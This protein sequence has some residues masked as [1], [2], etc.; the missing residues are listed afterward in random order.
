[1]SF[2]S[3]NNPCP[4]ESGLD[5]LY[6]CGA[7]DREKLNNI[8][9][10]VTEG[11]A[12]ITKL[13]PAVQS[14]IDEMN[15]YPD[16]FP[17]RVNLFS[18]YV[19]WVKMS[20]FWYMESVFLDADRI[21]GTYAFE[22][23]LQWLKAHADGIQWQPTPVIFHTAFCGSTLMSKALATVYD[24][25]PLRE[26]DALG[27]LMVFFQSNTI[28]DTEK[29]EWIG[30]VMRL[31]SRR[32]EPEQTTVVKAN[33]A[34]N[35]MMKPLLEWQQDVP[36]L[37]MYTPLSEF[38]AGCFKAENRQDWIRERNGF[39]KNTAPQL[40]KLPAGLVIENDDIG[41]MAAIYWCYNIALYLDARQQSPSQ[42]RS[43]EFNQMLAY[44]IEIIT[45][46][47]D[48]FQ[49]N[50]QSGIFFDSEIKNL[51]GIYSKGGDQPYSADT[52]RQEIDDL[53]AKHGDQLEQS[54]DLAKQ[55]LGE[56]YP[57]PYLPGSLVDLLP[58]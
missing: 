52:R 18:D 1:M 28:S 23:D 49:L 37:F 36:V 16:L 41:K 30:H 13:T 3:T 10:T 19:Q 56:Q 42:I 48:F 2:F 25:L 4:C 40:L 58:V 29:H 31:F 11:E 15:T 35:W 45:A 5:Y 9:N 32:F 47:G 50:Q 54:L 20:P 55:I 53:L 33:D 6:C 8:V 43:L 34:A 14:C 39:I 17:V 57:E 7:P 24:T 21:L 12:A 38:L 27:A 22:T 46:C 26:P 51:F 44:P